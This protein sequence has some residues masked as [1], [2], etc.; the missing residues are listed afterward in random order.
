MILHV[1]LF[2]S[3]K[4]LAGADVVAVEVADGATVADLRTALAREQ[5]RLVTLLE[6]SALAVNAEFA[7]PAHTLSA[8]DEI[9]LLPPV[10]GG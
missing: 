10:S 6:R 3:A 4:D 2:A 1:H 9:A 5:P 7:G 8:K